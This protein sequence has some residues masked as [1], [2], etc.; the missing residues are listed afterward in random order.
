[1]PAHT[2]RGV[3]RNT[4]CFKNRKVLAENSLFFFWPKPCSTN[5][6]YPSY[7][8]RCMRRAIQFRHTCRASDTGAAGLFFHISVSLTASDSAA[9]QTSAARRGGQ[10]IDHA[11]GHRI[12]QCR[13]LSSATS[14]DHPTPWSSM[15]SQRRR[16][17]SHTRWSSGALRAP[18][19]SLSNPVASSA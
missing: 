15:I 14:S 9:D 2:F 6:R 17:A 3:L 19:L 18:P 10:R 5:T 1:M 7:A 11:R 12:K 13:A 8:R 16:S 4:G